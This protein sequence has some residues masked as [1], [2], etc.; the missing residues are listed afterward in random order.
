MC[1]QALV[2]DFVFPNGLAFSPDEKI[3]Y[4]SD[5]RR[6][7]IRAFDVLRNGTLG[8]AT[9]RVFCELQG[10]GP[11]APDGMKVDVEGNVYCTGPGRIWIIDTSG[12]HLGTILTGAQTTN[13]GWGGEDWKTLFFTT[14]HTLGRIELK[15]P[16]IPVPA[17]P[18]G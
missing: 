3:I 6:G 13:I 10:E 7:H 18:L 8:I 14:R 17:K 9:D 16:G 4:I 2:R 12:K 15:V 11:G 5:F 1:E